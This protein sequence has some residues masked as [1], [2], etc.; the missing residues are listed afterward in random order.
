MNKPSSKPPIFRGS[1]ASKRPKRGNPLELPTIHKITFKETDDKREID[2]FENETVHSS[3][4]K[5]HSVFYGT[6]SGVSINSQQDAYNELLAK[7]SAMNSGDKMRSFLPS[8]DSKSLLQ[9]SRAIHLTNSSS[10][11]TYKNTYLDETFKW[12]KLRKQFKLPEL[13]YEYLTHMH[14]SLASNVK[15]TKFLDVVNSYLSFVGQD[16]ANL[17][18]FEPTY[19]VEPIVK[20]N[21]S[22]TEDLMRSVLQNFVESML[23]PDTLKSNSSAKAI[24]EHL[25]T[26]IK[27]RIKPVC[28]K[29][30]RLVVFTTICELK[31]Q[32]FIVA[33]KCLWNSE[34]DHSVF[35][36]DTFRNYVILVNLYAIY[37]E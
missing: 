1:N 18:R 27:N 31:H 23:E 17:P 4:F 29:R 5:D 25:T 12:R 35:I 32:D 13:K 6:E 16:S 28:D 20:F 21:P 36:K 33:S 14:G 3:E 9:H 8:S 19:R 2:P 7:F 24:I 10:S 11:D 37:K 15:S 26:T 22:L 30:Y 34:T